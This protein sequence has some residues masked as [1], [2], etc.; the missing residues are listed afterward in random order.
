MRLGGPE[1]DFLITE[2]TQNNNTTLYVVCGVIMLVG[3]LLLFLGHKFESAA[4]VMTGLLALIMPLIFAA[5]TTFLFLP[6]A[7]ENVSYDTS[8][9]KEWASD[10]YM[11]DVNDNQTVALLS[12]TAK[13]DE[14]W[15]PNG[16]FVKTFD[17]K[18]A[19]AFL[20]HNEK[21]WRLIITESVAVPSH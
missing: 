6:S 7:S 13:E 14:P 4:L 3:I 19:V 1:T 15:L 12:N 20:Y 21:E 10:T 16:V 18:D 17:G 9:F 11:V 8:A 2:A 5:V